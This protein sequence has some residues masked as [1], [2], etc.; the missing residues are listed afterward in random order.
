MTPVLDEFGAET[1]DVVA[2]RRQVNLLGTRKREHSRKPDKSYDV[3]EACSPRPGWNCSLR[4]RGWG[5]RL[6]EPGRGV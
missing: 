5:G 1:A 2:M 4:A 6:G 3:I